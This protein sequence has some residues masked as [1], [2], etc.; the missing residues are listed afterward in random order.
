M[1]PVLNPDKGFGRPGSLQWH[2]LH[3]QQCA[4]VKEL[5]E[6]VKSVTGK[7]LMTRDKLIQMAIDQIVEAKQNG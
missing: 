1:M 7:P 3:L 6:Y 2:T 5:N 4:T